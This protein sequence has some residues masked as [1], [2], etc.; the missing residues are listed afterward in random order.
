MTA[1]AIPRAQ[2]QTQSPTPGSTPTPTSSSS[3][4]PTSPTAAAS[5]TPAPAS[6]AADADGLT[7]PPQLTTTVVPRGWPVSPGATATAFL[8]VDAATGQVLAARDP[9][10]RRPVASTVKMLTALTVLARS[11]P[12]DRVVVGDEVSNLEG[13]SV[14]LTPGDDWSI[15][16]LLDGLLVRSGNDAATGL[17]VA[18]GGSLPGFMDLMRADASTLGLE[19][20]ELSTPN[21]LDDANQ[22]SARDLGVIARTAMVDPS[23]RTIVGALSVQL[24]G[25][26][27]IATRNLLLERYAGA[28]GIKTGY[29]ER[30]GWS[31]IGSAQRDGRELIAVVLGSADAEA[32]FDEA[33]ALLDFGFDGFRVASQQVE[34]DVA[35]AGGAATYRAAPIDLLVPSAADDPVTASLVPILAPTSDDTAMLEVVWEDQTLAELA[36]EVRAPEVASPPT[37]AAAVGAFVSNRAYEAMRAA[38]LVGGWA[39]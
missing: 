3:P 17:A 22:I 18:V 39:R 11:A 26:G 20:I 6:A 37:G 25:I 32:R 14:G 9:D 29:T 27:A 30:S 19:G 13:A 28:T 24:P 12:Q 21:G 2:A 16:Q 38:T 7:P 4:S 10:T 23:F 35:V 34:L 5:A 8:L 33:G 1:L 36:V 15:E 31:V